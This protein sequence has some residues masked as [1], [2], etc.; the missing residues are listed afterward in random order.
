MFVGNVSWYFSSTLLF[1]LWIML[2]SFGV[3]LKLNLPVDDYANA[4]DPD[5]F[6]D[7]MRFI[8]RPFVVT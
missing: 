6:N 5:H 4:K 2:A 3:I 8:V 7:V 1:H